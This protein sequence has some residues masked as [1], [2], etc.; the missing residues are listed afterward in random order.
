ME[1]MSTLKSAA[2]QVLNE[3]NPVGFSVE[4]QRNLKDI[5]SNLASMIRNSSLTSRRA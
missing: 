4:N 1:R 2:N 3:P 5:G